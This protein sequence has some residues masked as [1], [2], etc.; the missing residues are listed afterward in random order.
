MQISLKKAFLLAL[1]LAGLLFTAPAAFA[2]PHHHHHH[3]WYK[4][5][6][7]PDY[8]RGR[9]G[10]RRYDDDDYGYRRGGYGGWRRDDDDYGYRRGGYGGGGPGGCCLLR[11]PVFPAVLLWP[12]VV[13]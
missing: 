2:R 5:H 11:F 12:A 8:D 10:G 3:G 7:R 1:P 6:C 13:V 9:Y 4:R